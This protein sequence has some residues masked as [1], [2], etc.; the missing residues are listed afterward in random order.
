MKRTGFSTANTKQRQV[1]VNYQQQLEQCFVKSDSC[2]Y[3]WPTTL[4]Q[5][6]QYGLLCLSSCR[7]ALIPRTEHTVS[8][9]FR[10]CQNR[11]VSLVLNLKALT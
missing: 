7:G 4:A 2:H 11:K 3:L 6:R 8:Y 1:S 5:P 9:K 10:R